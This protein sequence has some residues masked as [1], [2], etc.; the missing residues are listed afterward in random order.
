[1]VLLYHNILIL[2]SYSIKILSCNKERTLKGAASIGSRPTYGD[3]EPNIEVFIF[4]FNENL[5][6]ENVSI[7]L[8]N[9]IRPELKFNTEKELIS[10]MQADC[11]TIKSLLR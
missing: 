9:Y 5:Y 2:Y 8:V 4:D 11:E 1:M 7:S 10:Q 3:Y 6:G